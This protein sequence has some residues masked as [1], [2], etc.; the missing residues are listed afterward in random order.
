MLPE[1]PL[2]RIR[3]TFNGRPHVITPAIPAIKIRIPKNFDLETQAA[4]L[5]NLDVTAA[6]DSESDSDAS[7]SDDETFYGQHAYRKQAQL[8]QDSEKSD[9]DGWESDQSDDSSDE[10]NL[11]HQIGQYAEREAD[12]ESDTHIPSDEIGTK[13]KNKD[14]L[15]CPAPHRLS[16][17]RLFAKHASLHPLLPE[18]HGEKRTAKLIRRDAVTEMYRHCKMNNLC[19]VWA[20]LWNSWYAPAKWRLWARSAH[21]ASIPVHRTTMVVEALWRNL[22]RLVLRMY[23]RPPLDL[24]TYALITQSIPPYRI[25][26]KNLLY[27]RG[28]GRPNTLTHMQ[29][30]FKRS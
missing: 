14:Y 6:N 27:D 22:K 16:I 21:E 20:Y 10:D 8:N 26:L 4:G 29:V 25:T 17:L 9:N 7:Q 30:V 11:C 28:G 23:N 3:L 13:S 12:L 24:A 15:F 2:A 18:R 19:E 5:P 1:R